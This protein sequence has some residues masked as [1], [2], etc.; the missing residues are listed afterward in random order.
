MSSMFKDFANDYV[1]IANA[2]CSDDLEKYVN[3]ASSNH[4]YPESNEDNACIIALCMNAN[5]SAG[6]MVK[7][8]RKYGKYIKLNPIYP[9][10]R[11]G[12]EHLNELGVIKG[13]DSMSKYESFF[14]NRNNV[15]FITYSDKIGMLD[16][17]ED[18][19]DP[20][21][22]KIIF[23]AQHI[24]DNRHCSYIAG[25]NLQKL[26]LPIFE[27]L[28]NIWAKSFINVYLFKDH[29]CNKHLEIDSNDFKYV[30]ASDVLE[31][32]K[33]YVNGKK[34][35][36]NDEINKAA[37]RAIRLI[38]NCADGHGK[39]LFAKKIIL[40]CED[41]YFFLEEDLKDA[42]EGKLKALVDAI[43]N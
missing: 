28:A 20:E 18:S 13:S 34:E 42:F 21:M 11:M 27:K 16:L 7:L 30:H 1:V 38:I 43:H 39:Y 41:F 15:P 6:Q 5:L 2:K 22:L 26:S 36:D 19:N 23:Y 17:I 10:H 37:N 4:E 8:G 40:E 3:I 12:D 9:I 24:I 32:F 29:F 35:L 31:V 14:N 25:K 33:N